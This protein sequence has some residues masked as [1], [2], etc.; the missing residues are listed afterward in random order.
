MHSKHKTISLGF[1]L[2]ESDMVGS[3]CVVVDIL[4]SIFAVCH[5]LCVDDLELRGG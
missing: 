3:N 5:D 1:N 2:I 4:K